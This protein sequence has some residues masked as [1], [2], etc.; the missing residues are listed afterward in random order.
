MQEEEQVY[1]HAGQD[2]M[3]LRQQLKVALVSL[4]LKLAVHCHAGLALGHHE[5]WSVSVRHLLYSS[6]QACQIV[7]WQEQTHAGQCSSSSSS[8][9]TLDLTRLV[10]TIAGQCLATLLGSAVHLDLTVLIHI[11]AMLRGIFLWNCMHAWLRSKY[12]CYASKRHRLS[13]KHVLPGPV[14]VATGE[15]IA[16]SRQVGSGTFLSGSG[17]LDLTQSSCRRKYTCSCSFVL[18]S[19]R[20]DTLPLGKLYTASNVC[21]CRLLFSVQGSGPRE[22]GGGG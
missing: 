12:V 5:V 20:P 19:A 7:L 17:R 9:C 4:L 2:G 6:E 16:C 13:H 11:G 10:Q 14:E 3:Q 8:S 22:G 15:C 21:I 1:L 18:L